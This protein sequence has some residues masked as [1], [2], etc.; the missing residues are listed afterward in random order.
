M[1]KRGASQNR[2]DTMKEAYW[3]L[4]VR[5]KKNVRKLY[6]RKQGKEESERTRRRRRRRKRKDRCMCAKEQRKPVRQ[7]GDILPRHFCYVCLC[8]L[9]R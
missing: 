1:K 6:S 4:L 7:R 5:K 2:A 3:M 9:T 8:P